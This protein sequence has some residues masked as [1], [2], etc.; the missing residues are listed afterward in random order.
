MAESSPIL[1]VEE[2]PDDV[3]VTV[4]TLR[5]ALRNHV[6][7]VADG[8]EALARIE[9]APPVLLLVALPRT[10][11]DQFLR[12]LG[13]SPSTREIPVLILTSDVPGRDTVPNASCDRHVVVRKPLDFAELAHALGR[14]QL[15][16]RL[17]DGDSPV[18]EA[19]TAPPSLCAPPV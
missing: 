17:T 15:S 8:A 5:G 9:S 18:T 14:L 16:L 4:R 11:R 19:A 13:A 12:G 10:T 6:I 1:L 7:V 2:A 3:A